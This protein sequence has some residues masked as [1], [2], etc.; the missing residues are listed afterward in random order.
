MNKNV[1]TNQKDFSIEIIDGI[2]VVKFN[3]I[4]ITWNEAKILKQLLESLIVANH[5]KVILDFSGT[6]FFDSTVAGVLIE[7]AKRLRVMNGDIMTVTPQ[8]SINKLFI[9]TRLNK[10]F[11]QFESTEEALFGFAS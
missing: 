7:L 8:M 2:S 10:I 4:R 6:I 3:L 9:Q 11:R 1:N 5:Y